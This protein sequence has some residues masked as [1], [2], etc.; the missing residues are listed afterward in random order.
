ML[1]SWLTS[2]LSP[3]IADSVQYSET[4]EEIWRQLNKRYGTVGGTKAFEIKKELAST[5]Q[6]S[7]DIASYFNKLKKLWDELRVARKNHGNH[8]TCCAKEGI[9]KEEEE[10]RLQ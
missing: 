6:G 4:A 3:D 7:L 1:I 2:S 8:C 5:C 9:L 10:D